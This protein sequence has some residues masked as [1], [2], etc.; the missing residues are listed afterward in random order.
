V[1]FEAGAHLVFG[2]ERNKTPC[3]RRWVAHSIA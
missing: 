2:P 1:G 3:E